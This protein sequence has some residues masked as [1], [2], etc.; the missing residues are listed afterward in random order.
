MRPAGTFAAKL[1][2]RQL[3]L[4]EQSSFSP[5]CHLFEP[6]R[7]DDLPNHTPCAPRGGRLSV[8]RIIIVD[9]Q[10]KIRRFMRTTLVAEG[11]E[12]DEAKSGEEALESVREL[13]PDLV[14]LD[15]N[16]P[17]MGGFRLSKMRTICTTIPL[18]S[19]CTSPAEKAT[20]ACSSRTTPITTGFSP[21]SR[22]PWA[23]CRILRK[24][25][26]GI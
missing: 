18:A 13:R 11:Y 8:G 17:A 5:P 21:R 10:P 14:V 1:T 2:Y 15:M 26:K 3:H 24:G 22:P 7:T 6:T 4:T 9:D 20:S 12:V 23:H 19:A 16:M 25:Q